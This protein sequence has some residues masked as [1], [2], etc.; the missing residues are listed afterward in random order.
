MADD[1]KPEQKPEETPKK[2]WWKSALD[3][4]GNALGQWLFGGNR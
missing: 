2:K 4:A 1:K 3:S